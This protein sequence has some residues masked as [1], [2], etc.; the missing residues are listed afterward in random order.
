[1]RNSGIILIAITFYVVLIAINCSNETEK[2]TAPVYLNHHDTVKYVGITVC[3]GCH[4]KVYEDFI[5]TGMGQSF[6]IASRQKSAA[7]FGEDA[8]V[9]DEYSD[10][11]YK[12]F[13]Q[14]DSLMIMEFRLKDGDTIHK[15]IERISYIIGSG[16]HT[17]SHIVNLHGYLF[18]APITYYTQRGVW[19]LAP[20]FEG[21]NNSRFSRII[22]LEC[23][24]CHNAYPDFEVG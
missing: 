21:G 11:Y 4:Y 23:M 15:R 9:Y 22:G 5:H 13:W 7:S 2:Q 16:Q 18:Q 8:L 6:D 10:L 12:P 19:D 14:D 24:T 1:M 3:R 17:N 20:G